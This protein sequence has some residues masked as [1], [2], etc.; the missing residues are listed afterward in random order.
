[1]GRMRNGQYIVLHVTRGAWASSDV[2]AR[3][4]STAQTDRAEY[5]CNK[6]LLPQDPGQAGKE[7]AQSYVK[8]LAGFIVE[9]KTVSKDKVTRAEPLAAQWQNGN[10]LLLEGE[11]NEV[12]LNEMESFPAALHDDQVD[13]A[14]DAFKAVAAANSWGGLIC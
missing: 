9:T 13:A 3:I 12:F 1:M 10:V 14:S 6:I 11:W 4:R 2:R 8:E 7:Q 5:N